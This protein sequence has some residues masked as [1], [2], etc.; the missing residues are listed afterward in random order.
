MPRQPGYFQEE[1]P[2]NTPLPASSEIAF[3]TLS[4]SNCTGLC[5]ISPIRPAQQLVE[6][7]TMRPAQRQPRAV[8]QDDGIFTVKQGLEFFDAFDVDDRRTADAHEFIC[9]K[10]ALQ[11]GH[12]LAVQM[13][14][15]SDVEFHVIVCG[16]DPVNLIDF[17][18]QHL[19]SGLDGQA[20]RML[21]ASLEIGEQFGNLVAELAGLLALDAIAGACQCLLKTSAV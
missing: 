12:R 4:R 15:V 21:Y 18:K 19:A 5:S 2:I 9:G 10:F 20:F 11:R 7:V 3:F 16:F 8:A 1:V 13:G 14:L 6:L 17:Q